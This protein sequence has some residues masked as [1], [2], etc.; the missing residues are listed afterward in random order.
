MEWVELGGV[1]EK[2]FSRIRSG[3][4]QTG[5]GQRLEKTVVQ[6]VRSESGLL[7]FAS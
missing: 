5:L 1:R 4:N 7:A 3:L 6:P 2:E